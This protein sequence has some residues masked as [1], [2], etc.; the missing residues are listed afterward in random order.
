MKIAVLGAGA[1]GTAL[2]GILEENNHKVTYFDPKIKD[3]ILETALDGAKY[4]LLCVPSE[5]AAKILDKLPKDVPLIVAT[6][7]FLSEEPFVNF[8]KYMII[9]GPGFADD[10]KEKKETRLTVTDYKVAELFAVDF[11][12]FDF[13]TDEQGVLICGALKNVYAIYAGMLGIK[14]GSIKHRLYIDNSVS[15]L[16]EILM[17]NGANSDTVELSCGKDDLSITCGPPSRNYEFGQML[18]KD[19]NAKSEKTVEGV[20]TLRRI[21]KGE[22]IVPETAKILKELIEISRKWD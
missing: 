2:G 13:T 11:I 6:K 17:I 7:G 5:A 4:I 15:E 21:Q 20:A 8:N 14:P 1:Y 12:T 16:K 9:S 19:I 18:R 22:I 3:C 10:I